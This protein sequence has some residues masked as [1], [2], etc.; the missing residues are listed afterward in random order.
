MYG[1][2]EMVELTLSIVVREF[3]YIYLGAFNNQE[4]L[5]YHI[6]IWY[7]VNMSMSGS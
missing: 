2:T 5:C 1:L 6:L 7:F 4:Y 3:M